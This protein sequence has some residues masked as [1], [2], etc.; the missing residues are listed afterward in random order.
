M[1]NR[2]VRQF[3]FRAVL[4]V[5]WLVFLYVIAYNRNKTTQ[6]RITTTT[7]AAAAAATREK[8][9]NESVVRK[10]ETLLVTSVTTNPTQ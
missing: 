3:D 8:N 7:A 9:K 1:N 6:S 10:A 4:Y 2:H 5:Y